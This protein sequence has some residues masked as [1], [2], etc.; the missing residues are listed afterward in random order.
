MEL[1]VDTGSRVVEITLS[2]RNLLS[3]LHKLDHMGDSALAIFRQMPNG[4]FLTFRGEHD[5]T[6]YAQREAGEMHPLT[7]KF[8]RTND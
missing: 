1:K 2:R 6:H 7:E 3:M 5:E 4:W 8:V